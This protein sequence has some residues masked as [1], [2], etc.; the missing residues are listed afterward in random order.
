QP[1]GALGATGSS[2]TST[3][4][5]NARNSLQ[6][7][8]D[9]D[10]YIESFLP[11]GSTLP[12]RFNGAS[13][14]VTNEG[15]IDVN[16]ATFEAAIGG[17]G[18]TD[19]FI[20]IS[21]TTSWDFDPSNGVP[22]STFDFKS[23]FIHEV[24]HALGFTSAADGPSGRTEMLDLYRFQRTDGTGDFNPDNV[25]EFGTTPR[26]I[27]FGTP[28]DDHNSN[29]FEADGTDLEYRMAD[30]NPNQAS[31][32]RE[33]GA[34][35]GIMD[36]T[37]A[38]GETFFPDY[39]Q[40]SDLDMLDAIGWDFAPESATTP[41]PFS[42]SFDGPNIDGALWIG[43]D[44]ATIN[45]LGDNPP[46]GPNSLNLNFID[47]V[48]S[49]LMDTSAIDT[50][51]VS[52]FWQRT[53]NSSSPEAGEDL[54]VEYRDST[55]A[56][57]ELARYPGA[58]PDDDPFVQD[59]F[60]LT[61][62]DNAT[63]SGFRLRFR[64]ETSGGA[65]NW[66]VDNVEVIGVN[67]P[68]NDACQFASLASVGANPFSSLNA[69]S[70]G[71]TETC[72]D[73]DSDVWYRVV[74]PCDGTLTVSV[75]DADFDAEL[76]IYGVLCPLSPDQAIA[77]NADACNGGNSISI[78]VSMNQ[79]YR[80]RIG[81]AGGA[82]GTGTLDISCGVVAAPACPWD[83]TPDNGDGTFGNGVVNIDDLLEVINSF[84]AAGGPCDSAP[85]NGDGTFGNN[86]IN[87]DDLLAV[88]NNF[89]ACPS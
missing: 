21:S 60:N 41:L 19:A 85:D 65:D 47:E 81:G 26:L 66:F 27:D 67:P 14:A 10:D 36:P 40:P 38:P 89:G 62:A 16:T 48:R 82:T 84:G 42:D 68:P 57:V 37:G 9:G 3:S 53:G 33:Q 30:G 32:F 44:G 58:G 25:T 28:N 63:H 54:V 77:C 70:E 43:I 72:A 64:V 75:C 49:A 51:I 59:T 29:L 31:H 1:L 56:W 2:A 46:S 69:T 12:V 45:G 88:I 73:F 18:G 17:I 34:A 86:I 13:S 39:F 52:Y 61:S 55:G 87:I 4:Y 22:F 11:S 35:I 74:T 6:S 76:A 7:D 24:G 20:T 78:P 15:T 8:M 50:V 83:C 23:T 5:T 80:I 71:S 79:L